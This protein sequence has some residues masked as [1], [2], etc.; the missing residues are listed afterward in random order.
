MTAP[1]GPPV[2]PFGVRNP[3]LRLPDFGLDETRYNQAMG[4][5][6]PPAQPRGFWAKL[7][8]YA[9][10]AIA[11][12]FASQLNPQ[13]GGAE[14]FLSGLGSGFV[15]QRQQQAQSRAERRQADLEA[16]K[17]KGDLFDRTQRQRQFD[18]TNRPTWQRE[19]YPDFETWRADR[20]NHPTG[21][22][23]APRVIGT[24]VDGNV[25][26]MVGGEV[27]RFDK[28]GKPM[29]DRPRVLPG[30]VGPD[31]APIGLYRGEG[32]VARPIDLPAG[33]A[34]KPSAG[35]QDD[36]AN[37]DAS[38][39][40][41]AYARQQIVGAKGAF[42]W[43]KQ[44][45]GNIPGVKGAARR[46]ITRDEAAKTPEYIR[47][48]AAVAVLNSTIRKAQAGTAVTPSE[49][50]VLQSFLGDEWADSPE[51]IAEKF[52]AVEQW[53]K[54]KQQASKAQ[55]RVGAAVPE[56]DDEEGNPFAD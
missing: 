56:G 51:V 17:M 41:L 36:L 33:S 32:G 38:L 31:N 35:Q 14:Q 43:Q 50:E 9:P 8:A 1:F 53:I 22:A 12:G 48:R 39:K 15:D 5:V 34:L 10:D 11:R 23:L 26:V 24:D 3:R 4:N 28:A 7:A 45:A 27:R 49:I 25:T 13:R 6:D 37:Y 19:G 21:Q 42:S 29:D 30:V 52:T 18:I 40:D 47:A 44:L 55:R 54:H 2:S 20:L 46:V 16:Y